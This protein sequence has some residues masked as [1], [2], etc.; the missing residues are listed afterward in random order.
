MVKCSGTTKAETQCPYQ[1]NDDDGRCGHHRVKG[2]NVCGFINEDD[3]ICNSD[4]TGR[5]T[6]CYLHIK[7][8]VC[9]SKTQAGIL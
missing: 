3:E 1:A 2:N 9:L 4:I 5:L 6:R 8:F 7:H